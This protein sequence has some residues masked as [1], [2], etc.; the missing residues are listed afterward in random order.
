MTLDR[1]KE[2]QSNMKVCFDS[3][4]GK[5]VMS[6]LEKTCCWYDTVYDSAD[7]DMTLIKAGR[8]EVL[9]T[10]KNMMR[11]TP[12]QIQVLGDDENIY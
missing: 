6:F 1:A 12:E 4:Q 5:D 10:I 11:L 7:R 2:L 3:P 8:R 9:A